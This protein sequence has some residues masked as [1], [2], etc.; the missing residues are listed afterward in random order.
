MVRRLPGAA[1]LGLLV[2]FVAHG[3]SYGDG[4]AMGGGYDDVLRSIALLATLAFTAFW[5]ALSWIIGKRL[6]DG[7]IVSAIAAQFIPGVPGVGVAALG[8]FCLAESIE[9][10]HPQAPVP[11][12]VSALLLASVAV[13]ILS[14]VV[15]RTL[16][17]IVFAVG[18]RAFEPRIPAWTSVADTSVQLDPLVRTRRLFSRPPPMGLHSV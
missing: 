15:L 6:R 10:G 4:H 14:R 8:W 3:V 12:I 13:T 5:V 9:S 16:A 1:T 17:K 11:L 7:S 18:W 2:A